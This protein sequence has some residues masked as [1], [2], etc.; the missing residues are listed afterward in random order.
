MSKNPKLT[1][2]LAFV[3]TFL[4][5]IGA[6]YMIQ[7]QVQQKITGEQMAMEDH[8]FQRSRPPGDRNQ[9]GR[10]SQQIARDARPRGEQFEQRREDRRDTNVTIRNERNDNSQSQRERM[11]AETERRQSMRSDKDEKPNR[12]D[13]TRFK[14]RIQNDLNLTDE[15]LEELFSILYEHREMVRE[16]IVENQRAVREK[17]HELKEQLELELSELLSEEQLEM[18]KEKF[19]PRL[20]R[21]KG[22]LENRE[23]D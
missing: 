14:R 4:V 17:Y 13:W 1:I 15:G 8:S 3:L 12:H 16:Q 23:E 20:E 21:R 6:G 18:W 2:A 19:A 10:E 22:G 11:R 9:M 5:G 7:G